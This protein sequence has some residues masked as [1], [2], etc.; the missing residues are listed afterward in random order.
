MLEILFVFF[1]EK[2]EVVTQQVVLAL[3]VVTSCES[4]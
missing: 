1:N 3:V 2:S 4:H